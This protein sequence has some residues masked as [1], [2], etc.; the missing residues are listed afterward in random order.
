[1]KPKHRGLLHVSSDPRALL[2]ALAR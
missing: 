1:M 2:D